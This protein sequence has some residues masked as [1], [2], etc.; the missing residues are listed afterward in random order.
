MPKADLCRSNF[1]QP[2]ERCA[3]PSAGE[4]DALPAFEAI[5]LE[6]HLLASLAR[7]LVGT[8]LARFRAV[9]WNGTS[10]AFSR[11][12]FLV[13]QRKVQGYC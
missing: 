10:R 13:D 9:R 8:A 2:V 5:A 1:S 12:R 3:V 4:L 6:R 11:A 7:S